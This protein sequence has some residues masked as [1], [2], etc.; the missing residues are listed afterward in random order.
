MVYPY[1][2]W[3]YNLLY[4]LNNQIFFHC[5]QLGLAFGSLGRPKNTQSFCNKGAQCWV[6][7]GYGVYLPLLG[8]SPGWRWQNLQHWF[9]AA[10]L[11]PK[12]RHAE[13][14]EAGSCEEG[15]RSFPPP[16]KMAKNI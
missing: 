7:A 3:E 8:E 2:T 9:F 11:S 6:V 16:K 12:K 1:I 15:A 5:S 4:T 14:L 10:D 13:E